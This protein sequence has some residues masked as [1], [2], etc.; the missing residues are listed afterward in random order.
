MDREKETQARID[1]LPTVISH[2]TSVGK[3]HKPIEG[4]AGCLDLMGRQPDLGFLEGNE[5]LYVPFKYLAS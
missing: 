4:L 5:L 2:T 3:I 1:G